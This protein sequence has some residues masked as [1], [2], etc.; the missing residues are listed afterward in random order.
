MTFATSLHACLSERTIF[1]T[2][3]LSFDMKR[4]LL[5]FA[6]VPAFFRPSIFAQEEVSAQP[7]DREATGA[8]RQLY[9]YLRDKVWGKQVLAGC[10]A[11][12]DY[13]TTDADGIYERA[14]KY[15]AVNIFD[16]QHFR[17]RNLN[18]M[19]P[20]AKAWHDAGGIVGF[21][22]HWSVPVAADLSAKEGFAFYT[23][24]GAEGRRSSTLFSPRRALQPGSPEHRIINENLDTIARYLLHYQQQGIPILWRPFHEAAGNTNRGGKAWFW[25]GSDGAEAFKQLYLYAQRYLMERGIHNLIYIWTSEL[26]DDDW[27]PGDEYVDI[28]GIDIYNNSSAS[29][30]NSTCFKMLKQHS[31]DKLIA[32]TEC[33]NLA[34]INAQWRSGAKWLYFAPWYDY[35]R[36][37]DVNSSEF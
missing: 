11:R 20:T 8:T 25:W 12:W 10:Q 13:D 2:F 28:V 27:Y 6:L 3:K 4:F 29:N 19:G 37:K 33:G 21:I 32:L 26:D 24:S 36:T 30:I 17:Q 1:F 7:I 18:Y 14:G 22:W 5:L 23:P 31:P 9:R 15:P 34:K 35:D 16:F